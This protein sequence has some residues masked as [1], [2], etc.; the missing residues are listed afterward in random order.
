MRTAKLASKARAKPAPKPT[1]K[2][3]NYKAY[4]PTHLHNFILLEPQEG[5][6]LKV[7]R[8]AL[9]ENAILNNYYRLIQ[10]LINTGILKETTYYFTCRDETRVHR[11]LGGKYDNGYAYVY[12]HDGEECIDH[13]NNIEDY[14]ASKTAHVALQMAARCGD[15]KSYMMIENTIEALCK[16]M[17]Y[18]LLSP[19]AVSPAAIMAISRDELE[20]FNYVRDRTRYYTEDYIYYANSLSCI[21]HFM[22]TTSLREKNRLKNPSHHRTNDTLC[23]RRRWDLFQALVPKNK[24]CDHIDDAILYGFKELLEQFSD[25]DKLIADNHDPVNEINIGLEA[26]VDIDALIRTFTWLKGLQPDFITS[27]DPVLLAAH[28]T[29]E[30]IDWFGDHGYKISSEL[31]K[32]FI[33]YIFTLVERCG[34]SSVERINWEKCLCKLRDLGVKPSQRIVFT[35]VGDEWDERLAEMLQKYPEYYTFDESFVEGSDIETDEDAEEIET[36]EEDSDLE[37]AQLD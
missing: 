20:L 2:P 26:Y 30:L 3:T 28:F 16:T 29:P 34:Y 4:I 15:L 17:G 37:D 19:Y 12:P 21:R 5:N 9:F 31:M 36:F 13:S 22:R 14:Q 25:I 27:I 32:Y 10:N 6:P 24:W 11:P 1:P 35:K 23:R 8:E 7:H 18:H 33:G